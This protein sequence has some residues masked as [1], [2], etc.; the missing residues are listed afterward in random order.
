MEGGGREQTPTH[1]IQCLLIASVPLPPLPPH[2][3]TPIPVAESEFGPS[4]MQ[5]AERLTKTLILMG[6]VIIFQR[7]LME[8]QPFADDS[9]PPIL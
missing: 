3:H 7:H 1:F 9:A 2:T 5:A 8:H 6:T 4:A